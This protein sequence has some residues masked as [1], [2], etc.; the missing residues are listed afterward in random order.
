VVAATGRVD[1]RARGR[2]VRRAR[3][4]PPA[5]LVAGTLVVG[6]LFAFP[7]GYLAWGVAGLGSDFFDIL[8]AEDIGEPLRNTLLLSATVALAATALGTAL[9][10]LVTRTNLPG[11]AVWRLVLP[12]PLVMPSFVGAFAL[13]AAFA[14]G[15]VVD[16]LIGFDR[17]PAIEGYW[18]AWAVLTLLT[19][20]YVYLPV[21][22]RLAALPRS[23]E[24][25]ARSLGRSPR[26]VF[27]TVVLP[28][29]TG[30][31]WAGALL[32]FLYTASEFGSVQLLRYETLTR[33]IFA[34]WLF[35]RDVAMSLSAVLATIALVV[36]VAERAIA[37]RRVQTDAVAP[38][39]ETAR[40]DLGPWRWL[41]FSFVSAVIAIAL[42]VPIVVLAHWT[43]RG[44]VGDA[45]L[46]AS[47]LVD[48]AITTAVL[49]IAAAVV[50]V[51]LVLPVAFLTVRHRSVAGETANAVIVSGFALPGLV[52]ALSIVFFVVQSSAL[53]DVVYQTFALLVFAYAVHFGAQTLRA[54]QVAVGGVPRR[55]EEAA[56]SLG[57]SRAR[58]FVSVQLPLMRSG[59]LAGAGLV[60]LSTMKELPATLILAPPNTETLATDIW[61]STETG[62]FAQAGLTSLV[63]LA[64]SAALTYVLTIRSAGRRLPTR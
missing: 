50:T 15:G 48:P 7:L 63:L 60:L 1:G 37:R 5:G 57:A 30:A 22:A 45:S 8:R 42:V 28:Q 46:D 52:L 53:S 16:V 64:L 44:L 18:A 10:W 33:A 62:R 24:E 39:S 3:S 36:V 25:S 17:A 59:L 6:A 35:D 32:V 12:L 29:C 23:L 38:S 21:A 61:H 4:R 41:A 27:R 43:L 51:A 56:Q 40:V 34:S 19:F 58:R 54:S 55:L 11:R 20:P 31:M 49:G 14:P 2:V 9:A 47:D 26:A 13:I